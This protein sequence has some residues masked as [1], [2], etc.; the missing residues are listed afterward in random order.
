VF[1]CRAG[2]SWAAD[3]RWMANA[4]M[5]G[6][7][8]NNLLGGPALFFALL[9]LAASQEPVRRWWYTLYKVLHHIGFWGFLL[10]GCMHHWGMFW[11]FVPGLL[12]YAVDGVF[13]LHQIFAGSS[14]NLSLGSQAT[15]PAPGCTGINTEVLRVDIDPAKTMCSLLLAAAEFGAAPAGIVWLNVPAISLIE[16]HAFDYTASQVAMAPDGTVSNGYSGGKGVSAGKQQTALSVHVKAY[17]RCVQG[18]VLCEGALHVHG[19]MRGTRGT[20]T[21]LPWHIPLGL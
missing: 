7:L 12:L 11:Y 4:L 14:G 5:S 8:T 3:G 18:P 16:W 6:P 9:L 10:A 15:A 20:K 2:L 1:A 19:I 13:R 17:S 21:A